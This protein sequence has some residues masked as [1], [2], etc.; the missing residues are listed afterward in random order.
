MLRPK[1]IHSFARSTSSSI[2]NPGIPWPTSPDIISSF[3][4]LSESQNSIKKG[5]DTSAAAAAFE[6][7]T[8]K[9]AMG[10]EEV[11]SASRNIQ[12]DA[13][14]GLIPSAI[15]AFCLA[16]LLASYNFGGSDDIKITIVEESEPA[17]PELNHGSPAH[18]I[19]KQ[20]H[21]HMSH[22][23]ISK[24]LGLTLATIKLSMS[25]L[26]SEFAGDKK[27]EFESDETLVDLL[28]EAYPPLSRYLMELI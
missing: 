13:Y 7:V 12:T 3:E 1:G 18:S 24:V 28:N 5:L 17:S 10:S 20:V 25:S 23:R 16:V 6:A 9:P 19:R 14:F 27:F 21:E 15:S 11:A 8:A 2:S 4:T 26:E 22:E